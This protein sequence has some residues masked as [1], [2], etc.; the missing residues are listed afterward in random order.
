[1]AKK[2]DFKSCP[3][4]DAHNHLNL[5][6]RYDLYE[7]WAGFTIPNFPRKLNGL[8]EMHEIIA[9]YTRPRI[10]TQQDVYD[11]ITLSVQTA[12]ED[13]VT[14][15]EG[16]IDISFIHHC[17]DSVDEYLSLVKS[18]VDKFDKKID[19]RP[20]LGVG[21]TFDFE[22]SK[23]WVPECIQSGVFKSIDLYG[24]EVTEGL[25][26]F[27]PFFV[28]AEKVGLKKKAHVGEFSDAQSVKDVVELFN[29]DEI[30][31]GIGAAQDDAIV[32]FLIDK[33]IR[34]NIC[35]ESNVM[36]SAVP[37]LEEHPMKKMYDAGVNITIGTDDVL[38]FNKTVCEQ[39]IDL[40]NLGIFT[41]TQIEDI[42]AKSIID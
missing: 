9:E 14:I 42:L 11:L 19:F 38:F 2:K 30:Q 31:H 18:V 15:L 27:Q 29:L 40:V 35:P 28:A 12:I 10:T 37:S 26:K 1:M 33:Q 17:A 23:K 34:L 32:Q 21:K 8:A 41:E 7:K 3:K 36:L 20:E 5:G 16:S 13:G 6:M 22:L 24:P 4:K 39:C 25:E